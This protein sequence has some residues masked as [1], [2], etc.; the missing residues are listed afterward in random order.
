MGGRKLLFNPQQIQPGCSRGCSAEGLMGNF[1]AE[2]QLLQVI[3]PRRTLNIGQRL[4]RR[5]V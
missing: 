5:I 1:A 3:K 2:G 4:N